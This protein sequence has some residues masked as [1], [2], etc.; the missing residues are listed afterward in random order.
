MQRAW[1]CGGLVFPTRS[2]SRAATRTDGKSFVLTRIEETTLTRQLVGLKF[3]LKKMGCKIIFLTA[4][5][6]AMG[7]SALVDTMASARVRAKARLRE[8]L[9]SAEDRVSDPKV[10]AAVEALACA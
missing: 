3:S 2:V 10:V 7:A 5:L 1:H 4:F 8:A 6:V 9:H